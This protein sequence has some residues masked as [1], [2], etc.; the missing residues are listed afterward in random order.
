MYDVVLRTC[1]GR[2]T[3]TVSKNRKDIL[4]RARL[5]K[6]LCV[7]RPTAR[8]LAAC[9]NACMTLKFSQ[10]PPC[11]STITS[12][13]SPSSISSSCGVWLA[14]IR[15]P[16]KRKRTCKFTHGTHHIRHATSGV[17][18]S[19]KSDRAA[20]AQGARTEFIATPCRLQKACISFCSGV[21]ILHLKKISLPS[22]GITAEYQ[23]SGAAV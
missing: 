9:T 17:I 7:N 10:A 4:E 22:A 11:C 21:V 3:A 6:S 14:L 1:A 18:G 23:S 8:A 15:D 12:M 16:S 5:A 2:A 19:S 13:T 20:V